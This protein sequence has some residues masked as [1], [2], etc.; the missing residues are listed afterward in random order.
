MKHLTTIDNLKSSS[1]RFISN[2]LDD[3]RIE[4]Y[5]DESEQ[6]DIKSQIGDSLFLDIIDYI[7]A[8]DKSPFPDYSLLLNGGVYEMKDCRGN[9]EKRSFKGLIESLN[10]YVWSRIVKNNN[11]SVTRFGTVTKS[12][13][14]SANTELKE[15]LAVE[16]DALSIAD[17]YMSECI[18]YLVA[19]RLKYPLFKKGKQRN[20]LNITII[21]N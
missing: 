16:K 7:N 13:P 9:T 19:N 15:R 17:R 8:E 3:G 18:N 6:I 2:K 12:D 20:R 1:S 4:P 10:Y 5:I 14:Y 11:Y 21:G